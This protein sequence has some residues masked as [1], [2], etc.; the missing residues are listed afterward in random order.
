[1]APVVTFTLA[2]T[3]SKM[4]VLSGDT[5]AF[6]RAGPLS[7]LARGAQLEVIGEGFSDSTVKVLSKGVT[8]FIF[9][10]DLEEGVDFPASLYS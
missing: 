1:M 4:Y 2:A 10:R 3:E 7:R 5:V 6:E 8:Y 9:R